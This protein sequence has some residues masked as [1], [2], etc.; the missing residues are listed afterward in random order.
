MTG[1]I[2]IY[3]DHNFLP[4]HSQEKSFFLHNQGVLNQTEDRYHAE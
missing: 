2:K 3:S 1:V 4:Q